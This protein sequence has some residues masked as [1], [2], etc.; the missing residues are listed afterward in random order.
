MSDSEQEFP[1]SVD[2]LPDG[3][4]E[5]RY[6]LQIQ[7]SSSVREIWIPRFASLDR[8][9]SNA[10]K[11]WDLPIGFVPVSAIDTFFINYDNEI[12]KFELCDDG[13]QC[14]EPTERDDIPTQM[15]VSMMKPYVDIRRVA[16]SKR[17]QDK[18]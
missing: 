18:V 10:E 1:K 8:V 4:V 17:Q 5:I 15:F 2:F 6:L 7:R 12:V 16:E 14:E 13:W 11:V 9:D 3:E